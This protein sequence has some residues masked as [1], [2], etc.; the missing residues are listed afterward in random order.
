[1]LEGI[2]RNIS[3]LAQ[4]VGIGQITDVIAENSYLLHFVGIA[5]I[6]VLLV[7]RWF[8]N[9]RA[10]DRM[11]DREHVQGLKICPNCTEQLPLSA[12]I[13]E[14][15]DFN[16]LSGMVGHGHRLLAAPEPQEPEIPKRNLA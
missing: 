1:M 15:C 7:G 10:G 16:F 11:F 2:L 13:C 9:D 5:L 6:L 4:L 3:G 12:L 8:R 14:A